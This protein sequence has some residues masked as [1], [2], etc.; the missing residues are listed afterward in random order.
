MDKKLEELKN[1]V[2]KELE[3]VKDSEFLAEL[4]VKYLGRKGEL[5]NILKEVKTLAKEE[6]PHLSFKLS[7]RSN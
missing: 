3:N 6:K 4:K 5:T 7:M 2:I 1:S